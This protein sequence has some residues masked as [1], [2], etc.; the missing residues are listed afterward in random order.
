M[1]NWCLLLR[2]SDYTNV[3]II[4][5]YIDIQEKDSLIETFNQEWDCHIP[6]E[7]EVRDEKWNHFHFVE[8]MGDKGLVEL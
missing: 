1:Y 7:I 6:H 5:L 4:N 2:K 8:L 3:I